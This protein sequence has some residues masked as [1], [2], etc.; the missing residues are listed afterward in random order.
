MIKPMVMSSDL[1]KVARTRL[2]YHMCLHK[3]MGKL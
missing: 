2:V 1:S 3:A